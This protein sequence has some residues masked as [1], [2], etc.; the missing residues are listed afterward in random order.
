MT[1]EVP[2]LTVAESVWFEGRGLHSGDPTRVGVH[3]GEQGIW[4]RAG[5]QRV[6][7]TATNVTDTQRCTVLGGRFATVEHILSALAGLGITD[8]EV[9]LDG[10]EL[11][12]LD[13]ACQT[14]ADRFN[15]TA[16]CG[17]LRVIGPF[18]RIYH[19]EENLKVAMST[20]AGHW[21]Y[22]YNVGERWPGEQTFDI[23]LTPVSYLA[24]VAPARTFALEEELPMIEKAGLARGLDQTTALILGTTDYVNAPKFPD[25]PAR[26]KLLDLIGDL[27]LSGVPIAALNVV[28]ERSGHRSNV[29]AAIKLADAVKIERIGLS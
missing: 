13:G 24:N 18:A 19:V 15:S 4:F 3:P 9:E 22:T 17:T 26:H 7:A 16:P 5:E 10:V 21:R 12:A 20:G 2:R 1:V 14:Y 8:A 11:P 25:E 23:A 27:S 6:A 29:A 28:A